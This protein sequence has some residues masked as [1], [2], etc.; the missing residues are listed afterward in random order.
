VL[1]G[2]GTISV[3]GREVDVDHAG[4]YP[5]IEHER[6]SQGVLDLEVGSGVRCHAVCFTA[7]LA[8]EGAVPSGPDDAL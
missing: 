6:H 1:D 7:G 3:N 2:T 8:P 4:A 5:L